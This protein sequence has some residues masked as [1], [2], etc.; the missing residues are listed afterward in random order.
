ME[1]LL[2]PPDDTPTDSTTA[3]CSTTRV[4]MVPP[5]CACAPA[6]PGCPVIGLL[7]LKPT[8]SNTATSEPACTAPATASGRQKF[9]V[10]AISPGGIARPLVVWAGVTSIGR[11]SNCPGCRSVLNT[12]EARS[13]GSADSALAGT[14]DAGSVWLAS[15]PLCSAEPATVPAVI[16][17]CA[18]STLTAFIP[19][20]ARALAP[21]T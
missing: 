7:V 4:L 15:S 3:R 13:P 10:S 19:A 14:E 6:H 5:V 2:L 11:S 8:V 9:S 17:F 21:L 18:T 16:P 12:S 20:M 1:V